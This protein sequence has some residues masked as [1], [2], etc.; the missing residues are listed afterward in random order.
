MS[1]KK[2][3]TYNLLG[4]GIPLV[5][6]AGAI[7]FLLTSMGNEKFGILILIWALI[8]YFGLFDFGIGRALTFEVS[9]RIKDTSPVDLSRIIQTGL[10]LTVLTG[11]VGGLAV[12]YLLAPNAASWLK[13]SASENSTAQLTFTIAALGIIPT[14]LTS[15]L[16]GALE[17]L[18]RFR[19]SNINRCTLG[20]LMFLVPA[21]LV[22]FTEFDLPLLATGLILTRYVV[23]AMA[24]VQLRMYLRGPYSVQKIEVR[25]LLNYGMWMT[26]SSLISAL[27]VYGDR[28]FVSATVGAQAL[29]LYA[30]PQ[31]GLQKLLIIPAALAGA[32]IPRFAVMT[33][34]PDLETAYSVNITRVALSMLCVCVFA[35]ISVSPIL[36]HWISED[37]SKA[38]SDLVVILCVGIWWNSLAQIPFA[39]LQ[40]RGFA[41]VVGLIHSIELIVYLLLIYLLTEKW[42]VV[43]AAMAWS[44]RA[45]L[46]FLLLHMAFK[47]A[48][49][50]GA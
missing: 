48:A 21:L 13:L 34:K 8:G 43:G 44:A 25:S 45:F 10:G 6:A 31:E 39:A 24:L 36:K 4:T 30:I 2:D 7:P 41:K 46:D 23:C 28:F 33:S 14:T 32:L 49:L 12:Y 3:T 37:F 11:M 17:G 26:L 22:Y 9:R 47:K 38:T 15:G 19:E 1:L 18:N 5:V 42:G 29:P 16:R 27:M 35:S 50:Q 40:A 20:T